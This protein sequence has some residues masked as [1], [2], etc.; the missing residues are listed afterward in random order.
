[1]RTKISL[2]EQYSNESFKSETE[3]DIICILCTIKTFLIQNYSSQT[4][5]H[6]E[7]GYDILSTLLIQILI[8]KEKPY[9]SCLE[10]IEINPTLSNLEN[11]SGNPIFHSEYHANIIFFL[12]SLLFDTNIQPSHFLTCIDSS[13]SLAYENIFHIK[14]LIILEIILKFLE[15][16]Q[17]AAIISFGLSVVEIIL[18]LNP[19]TII[20]IQDFGGILSLE[21]NLIKLIFNQFICQPVPVVMPEIKPQLYQRSNRSRSSS[22]GTSSSSTMP[23]TEPIPPLPPSEKEIKEEQ[24][25]MKSSLTLTVEIMHLLV[26]INVICSERNLPISTFFLILTFFITSRLSPVFINTIPLEKCSNCEAE[27]AEYECTHQRFP[28]PLSL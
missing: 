16:D 6:L 17:P 14:N 24:I 4:Q 5:F 21:K 2:F 11:D 9:H 28:I 1:M 22:S 19:L 20:A 3:S 25:L 18:R 15:N 23:S 8:I 27:T 12:L 7:G 13:I 10:C 26:R